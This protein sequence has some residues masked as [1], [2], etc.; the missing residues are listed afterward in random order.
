M[1]SLVRADGAWN[2][3]IDPA[4]IAVEEHLAIHQSKERVVAAHADANAR[5][6]LG[7][8]LANNDVACNHGLTAGFFEAESFATGIATV[9]DGVSFFMGQ[10]RR[11][12]E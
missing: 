12:W 4:A 8:T 9:L 7:A 1:N 6:H 2:G 11:G 5:M 10:C 3:D